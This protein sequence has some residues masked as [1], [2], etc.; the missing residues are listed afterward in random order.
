MN[1]LLPHRPPGSFEES[2]RSSNQTPPKH[3]SRYYAPIPVPV[4]TSNSPYP[5]KP[6]ER[7]H[8]FMPLHMFY[9]QYVPNVPTQVCAS[10]MAVPDCSAHESSPWGTAIGNQTQKCT[11]LPNSNTEGA[12]RALCPCCAKSRLFSTTGSHGSQG[13]EFCTADAVLNGSCTLL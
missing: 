6:G 12:H 9:P 4:C 5:A 11:L 1:I 8:A 13:P 7:P 3:P 2:L 10:V